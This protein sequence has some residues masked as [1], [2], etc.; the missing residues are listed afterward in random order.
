MLA[1]TINILEK[2]APKA[3]AA[4]G[5]A[6]VVEVACVAGVVAEGLN[7]VMT[8]VVDK[9]GKFIQSKLEARA[10][11]AKQELLEKKAAYQAARAQIEA[12]ATEEEPEEVEVE[13]PKTSNKK[14]NK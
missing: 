1:A 12:A 13:K 3:V 8:P 2:V 11:A 7:L 14:K 9:G 6:G 10:K 5:K 4:L